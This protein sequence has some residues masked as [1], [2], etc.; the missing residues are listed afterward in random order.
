[1]AN[2]IQKI[3][4]MLEK[5]K[6]HNSSFETPRPFLG[7]DNN[8]KKKYGFRYASG[9]QVIAPQ[10]DD[11]KP[12]SEGLAAVCVRRK[13]IRH[14]GFIREDGE[15]AIDFQF[16]DTRSF[17]GGYAAVKALN[18]DNDCKQSGYINKNGDWVIKPSYHMALDFYQGAAPV[19]VCTET[20]GNIFG[21]VDA[22][23]AYIALPTY[24]HIS[25]FSKGMAKYVLNDSD[26]YRE[27][28][29]LNP[30]GERVIDK[31][32][33]SARQPISEGLIAVVVKDHYGTRCGFLNMENDWVI[34]P[35]FEDVLFFSEGLAAV[36]VVGGLWGYIDKIGRF[37]I[38]PQFS[39]AFPFESGKA[40]VIFPDNDG[41]AH[42]DIE[43]NVLSEKKA[44]EPHDSEK[45]GD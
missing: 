4:E 35:E 21:L 7:D 40:K 31:K 5:E 26:G 2:L 17:S 39:R 44:V 32:I 13:G 12:F 42:I 16:G 20:S 9:R 37:K 33:Y 30:K 38:K 23:G 28:G 24:K 41:Y 15:I 19:C 43:G 10:F 34:H 11:A 29:F 25:P 3:E 22:S 8:G 45:G 36:K 6:H 18:P 27:V 14:W 1:M